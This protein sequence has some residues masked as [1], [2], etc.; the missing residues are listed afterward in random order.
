MA[1]GRQRFEAL[2]IALG[3]IITYSF[4]CI[5][6]FYGIDGTHTRSRY[7]MTL[8]TM[9]GIDGNN[10]V[11]PLAWALVPIES[12]EWWRWFLW[13]VKRAFRFGKPLNYT[14]IGLSNVGESD[15]VTLESSYTFIS[16]RS[17]GIEGGLDQVF[18]KAAHS[19][20]CQHIA[21]N[22]HKK[23]GYCTPFV[24]YY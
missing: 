6:H 15:E 10:N 19:Y 18:E 7:G 13:H 21:D 23:S 4:H 1:N 12:I 16:D 17:K 20:C 2:F 5:R 9:I 8:L 24:V 22:L 11:L 3:N 14:S